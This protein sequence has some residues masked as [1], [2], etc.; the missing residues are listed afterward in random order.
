MPK[1]RA[2][3]IT[4]V[5]LVLLV[6]FEE[7]VDLRLLGALLETTAVVDQFGP[8]PEVLLYSGR[9]GQAAPER[10]D[11]VS[12]GFCDQGRHLVSCLGIKL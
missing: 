10:G 12:G 6:L 1:L 5:L 3:G 11:L 4:N 7:R 2:A 8:L 9:A